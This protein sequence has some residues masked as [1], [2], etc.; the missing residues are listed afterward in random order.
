MKRIY[1]L[2]NAATL[3]ACLFCSPLSGK[4][5]TPQPAEPAAREYWIATLDRTALPVLTA[6]SEQRLKTAMPLETKIDRAQHVGYLEAFGRTLTG[7][8]PWLEL[9]PDSTVEGRKRARYIELVL[10][11][12]DNATNPES[13][14]CMNF[15]EYQQPL[16]DAAFLAHGLVRAPKQIWGRLDERVKRQV[17]DALK[18]TRTIRTPTNNWLLFSGIIEAFLL[19]N[20]YGGD[21]M[22]IDFAV[23]K[24]LE[25]Y[26]GDGTYS[27]GDLFQWDYYNSFVIQPMLLDVV[28]ILHK[29]KLVS[30]KT[31]QDVQRRIQRYA[32]VQERLISP[33]GAFP[34]IGRSLAYRI[35]AFQA[36]GQVA[37]G[38]LLPAEVA[39]AQ[40][41]C[42]LTAVM[43]RMMEAP[44]T[45]D[46]KGW[47]KIGFC[48]AQPGIG[49]G[50]INTGSLYL[51][52]AGFLPLGLP[53]D[54]PFWNAPDADWTSLK[55]WKGIDL[56]ADH[57]VN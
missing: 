37:L 17:V 28:R 4:C 12:L 42:A 15:T 18:S 52:C 19:D 16:V 5:K 6:L 33:E 38:H 49:E 10:K 44:G 34:P 7:I 26:K 54:D 51:C 56:P 39:P 32:A 14:D 36:L 47:L 43:K 13:A 23:N 35:G 30:D 41:R 46:E 55:L 2:L 25:R 24:H 40:V 50:Y 57:A 11:C 45:F 27:D 3:L 53:A 9:G 31:F 29:R 1:L 22:R 20:D 21:L 8:A 48:G